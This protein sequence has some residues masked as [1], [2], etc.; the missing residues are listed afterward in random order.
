MAQ[1]FENMKPGNRSIPITRITFPVSSRKQ[2]LWGVSGI[3]HFLVKWAPFMTLG[4]DLFPRNPARF[5][6]ARWPIDLDC[7]YFA[8]AASRVVT[9]RF[10]ARNARVISPERTPRRIGARNSARDHRQHPRWHAIDGSGHVGAQSVL[11]HTPADDCPAR[12]GGHT[13][14]G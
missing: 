12:G 8:E 5:H 1:P 2:L 9:A 13:G 4:H 3:R 11:D 10:A 14:T 6:T 7:L